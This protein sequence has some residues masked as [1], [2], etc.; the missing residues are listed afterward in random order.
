M[1]RMCVSVRLRWYTIARWSLLGPVRMKEQCPAEPVR[2]EGLEWPW[3][4][5]KKERQSAGVS[6]EVGRWGEEVG[7]T[8]NLH[9]QGP[10]AVCPVRTA[11]SSTGGPAAPTTP[12]PLT[13]AAN[14]ALARPLGVDAPGVG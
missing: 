5:K 12:L 13:C 2:A 3:V 9:L 4:V 6:R 14:A 11:T 7:G 10:Q 1:G 8:G